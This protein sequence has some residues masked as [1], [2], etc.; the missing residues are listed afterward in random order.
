MYDARYSETPDADDDEWIWWDD[1]ET[2]DDDKDDDNE[3]FIRFILTEE[4]REL[5]ENWKK[6]VYKQSFFYEVIYYRKSKILKEICP[7]EGIDYPAGVVEILD[8]F[9]RMY[10]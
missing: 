3:D 10:P 2:E 8:E 6:L 4:K 5:L 1:V 9:N 7:V